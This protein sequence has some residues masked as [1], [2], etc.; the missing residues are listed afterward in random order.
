MDKITENND[1]KLEM[2]SETYGI[3]YIFKDGITKELLDE[4]NSVMM[5]P[6]VRLT[7]TD[8]HKYMLRGFDVCKGQLALFVRRVE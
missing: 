1:I 4:L 7:H 6:S 8:G 5:T 3:A 2:I